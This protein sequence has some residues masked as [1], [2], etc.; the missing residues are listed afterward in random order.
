MD[1]L[2]AVSCIMDD[3]LDAAEAGLGQGNSSFHK[4]SAPCPCK[5]SGTGADVSKVGKEHRLMSV[6]RDCVAR[7]G[8]DKYSASDTRLR[9]GNNA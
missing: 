1:I 2:P 9:T 7:K 6:A 4:V 3:D 8:Y 5:L